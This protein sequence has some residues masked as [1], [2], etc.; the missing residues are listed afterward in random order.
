MKIY[1]FHAKDGNFGD[2]L[3]DWL[4]PRLLDP[5]LWKADNHSLVAI[6]SILDRRLDG[7]TG[8]KTVFGAGIRSLGTLPSRNPDLKIRFV[9][10]PISSHALGDGTPWITDPAIAI[11]LHLAPPPPPTEE[12]T[13]FM[14]HYHSIYLADWERLCA[15][16][17]L[18]YIDPRNSVD[19]VLEK[20][21]RCRALI[22]EAMH[23][24][25][26]ADTFRIPWI[27]IAL[28]SW[29]REGFDVAS[30][31][32]LDW[33]LSA[34]A[35]TTPRQWTTPPLQPSNPLLRVPYRLE[36]R[37]SMGRIR[38]GLRQLQR[39]A[40]YVLSPDS[41]LHE[42]LERIRTEL[43]RLSRDFEVPVHES[44]RLKAPSAA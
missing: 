20:L 41:R 24:A 30:L 21:L 16:F 44:P 28:A 2:D 37:R 6:G 26:I 8:Q 15:D 36:L 43:D 35:D 29:R 22:T 33:G 9:R 25:I 31:K 5:A 34:G 7:I 14:P 10:G 40:P 38:T 32:W 3:N 39:E 12:T 1:S 13:G 27:R 18:L 19:A 17:G 23:G 4:W 11:R 42:N